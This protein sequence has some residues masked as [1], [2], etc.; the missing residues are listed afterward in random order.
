MIIDFPRHFTLNIEH[1]PHKSNY[2]TIEEYIENLDLK[3]AITA[4]DLKKCK[5]MDSL[6]H[7]Q[8]YPDTPIGFHVILAYSL[9]R[10]LELSK[11][12]TL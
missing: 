4:E 10:C 3:D 6:W 1:N 11:E 2:Q 7:F 8:W 5:E 12:N 9:E